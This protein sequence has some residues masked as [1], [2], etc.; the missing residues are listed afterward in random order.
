M[1]NKVSK[2]FSFA[3]LLTAV[4]G[5]IF[6]RFLAVLG[7]LN[8]AAAAY[9]Y[10]YAVGHAVEFAFILFLFLLIL[11]F[12]PKKAHAAA[13]ISLGVIVTLFF[14][15]ELIVF[16]QFRIHIGVSI[17][18][19]FF[20]P[21]GSEIFVFPISMYVRAGLIFLTTVTFVVFLWILSGRLAGKLGK[22]KAVLSV[23]FILCFTGYNAVHA[24]ANFN[25]Y[26]PVTRQMAA[27]PFTYPLSI[28]TYLE[29]KGYEVP[30]KPD[31]FKVTDIKY[32]L[33]PIELENPKD[34]NIVVIMV[35]CWRGD[36]MNKD[37]TPNI[38]EFSRNELVF[39][40]HNS[41]SNH[42]RHSIFSF[43]YG[44]PGAYWNAILTEKVSPVLMDTI[45]ARGYQTGIFA[46]SP[47]NSPEFDKT[48][49]LNVE[50]L[51]VKSH[52][53]TTTARDIAITDEFINFID[54]R[55]KDKPFFSFM[56]YD[57]PHAYVFDETLYP[58]KFLPTGAKNYLDINDAN[59]ELYFNSYRNS[60][61]FVDVLVKRVLDKIEAE[62]LLDN[63]I[64]IITGDH[65][66][67]FNEL[68]KGYW[69]HNGNYSRY[70]VQV[71]MVVHWPGKD[72]AAFNYS[73]SHMDVAVTLMQDVFGS[74]T[75]PYDYT[76]GTNLFSPTG[77]R[78]IYAIGADDEYAIQDEHM[79]TV[80]PLFGSVYTVNR[81]TYE[82]VKTQVPME[83]LKEIIEEL[84]RFKK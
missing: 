76:T 31:R 79:I 44:I 69:G 22:L 33:T 37:A 25:E 68:G 53:G 38:Y 10:V 83:R 64:V 23:L 28:N 29:S 48:V 62:N 66:Q 65:G 49:F 30:E 6:T 39:N 77:R 58:A 2:S 51:R 36:L 41:T 59:K 21:A 42:T 57:S 5:A 60:I 26:N 16:K 14:V 3:I 55:D 12:L 54:S 27:L 80:F 81:D 20:G 78:F 47:L 84:S 13:A 7:D 8:G 75:P 72:K 24:W 73:T 4:W 9:S 82:P 35:E 61:G 34:L 32:P 46:S 11:I 74:V 18:S 19:M 50:N 15:V 45:L 40:A 71:P 70:Q 67:E 52:Q 1:R 17:I 56:F 63:T 43:F